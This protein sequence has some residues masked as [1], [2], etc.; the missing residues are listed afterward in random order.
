M[1]ETVDHNDGVH[2]PYWETYHSELSNALGRAFCYI[3]H[4]CIVN[5]THISFPH[6]VGHIPH[7][8]DCINELQETPAFSS[9]RSCWY[10]H[11]TQASPQGQ[12]TSLLTGTNDAGPVDAPV[13]EPQPIASEPEKPA[14]TRS[15]KKASRPRQTKQKV[16]TTAKP[17]SPYHEA[18]LTT[19]PNHVG[20]DGGESGSTPAA[21]PPTPARKRS[22]RPPKEGTR[23]SARLKGQNP[24]A[25]PEPIPAEPT[26]IEPKDK[27]G[28]RK[29][30]PGDKAGVTIP[31]DGKLDDPVSNKSATADHLEQPADATSEDNEG[32]VPYVSP[33]TPEERAQMRNRRFFIRVE[34]GV[35]LLGLGYTH[36]P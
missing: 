31:N 22:P 27:G 26:P 25:A 19:P 7:E 30:G 2:Y 21:C 5:V 10:I 11:A 32:E 9:L 34:N 28:K 29:R 1:N 16:A 14:A 4:D 20:G 15:R 36:E 23:A 3:T 18:T 33:F 12:L 17:E 8:G 13:L 24:V 35:A 6:P